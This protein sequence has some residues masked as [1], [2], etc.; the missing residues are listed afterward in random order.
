MKHINDLP[1]PQ[2]YISDLPQQVRKELEYYFEALLSIDNNIVF[3]LY[4]S[5]SLY[6]IYLDDKVYDGLEK[7]L[8]KILE[9]DCKLEKFVLYAPERFRFSYEEKI[10]VPNFAINV[11]ENFNDFSYKRKEVYSLKDNRNNMAYFNFYFSNRDIECVNQ[12]NKLP[13]A[14]YSKV[15]KGVSYEYKIA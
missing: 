11:E 7:K 12:S 10:E 6:T 1:Q 14:K 13:L 5:P 15:D 4:E 3:E 2:K 9:R 8:E